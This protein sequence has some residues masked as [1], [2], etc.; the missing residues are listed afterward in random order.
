MRI[1]FPKSFLFDKETQSQIF[2]CMYIFL[3]VLILRYICLFQSLYIECVF[4]MNVPGQSIG[5]LAFGVRAYFMYKGYIYST[6]VF[7][8]IQVMCD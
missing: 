4:G 1:T 5:T 3:C 7:A 6:Y 8:D 2:F